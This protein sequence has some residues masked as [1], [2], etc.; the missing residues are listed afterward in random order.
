ML[1]DL[2]GQAPGEAVRLALLSAHYRQPLGW[3]SQTLPQAVRTLSR[4]YAA[5]GDGPGDLRLCR[6]SPLLARFRA[7]LD[8][9]LNTPAALAGLFVLATTARSVDPE[10]RPRYVAALV[11]AGRSLACCKDRARLAGGIGRL[12]RR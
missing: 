5:I 10:L 8:D 3:T 1:R 9:D 12:W 6:D 2:Q 4:L 7:A 11:E